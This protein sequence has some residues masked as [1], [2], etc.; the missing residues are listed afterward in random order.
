M[1]RGRVRAGRIEPVEDVAL[2]EGA[3]VSFMIDEPGVGSAQALAA[4]ARRAPHLEPGDIEVLERAMEAG[5]LPVRPAG[6]FDEAK[7]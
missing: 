3:E 4:A 7:D 2:P 5:K 6:I 1:I